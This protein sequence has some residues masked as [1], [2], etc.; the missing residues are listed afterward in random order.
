MYALN[1]QT[2]QLIASTARNLISAI[3]KKELARIGLAKSASTASAVPVVGVVAGGA[4]I[5]ALA[6]PTSRRWLNDRA[7]TAYQLS[8]DAW[9]KTS[10]GVTK[11]KAEVQEEKT[12]GAP[13]MAVS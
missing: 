10:E 1:P 12:D 5:T 6:I 11:V 4:L 13:V 2:L 8:R 7:S 9:S 3:P